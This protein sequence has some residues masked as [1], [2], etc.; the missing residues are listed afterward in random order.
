MVPNDTDLREN[1]LDLQTGLQNSLQGLPVM[2]I[3]VVSTSRVPKLS[4]HGPK[5]FNSV[6]AVTIIQ[7]LW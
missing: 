2:V 3:N 7:N 5:L 4:A 6:I 1:E